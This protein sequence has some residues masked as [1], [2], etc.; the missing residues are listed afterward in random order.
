MGTRMFR[1]F[2]FICPPFWA[3]KWL[4]DNVEELY[5]PG[6]WFWDGLQKNST[7]LVDDF[8]QNASLV[9]FYSIPMAVDPMF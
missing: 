6:V 5:A 2:A 9:Y 7:L 4:H 8:Q 3:E 1:A